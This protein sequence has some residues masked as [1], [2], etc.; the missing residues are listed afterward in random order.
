MKF[1]DMMPGTEPGQIVLVGE[2]SYGALVVECV[3]ITRC[4]EAADVAA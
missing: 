4:R 2:T 1:I 3:E